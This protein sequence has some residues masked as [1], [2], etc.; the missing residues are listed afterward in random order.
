MDRGTTTLARRDLQNII[1]RIPRDI[2]ALMKENV[3]FLGGGFLRS[4]I[5]SEPPSDIDLFGPDTARLREQAKK[6]A[7]DRGGKMHETDNA[8]T[9]LATGRT[10]VQFIHRWLYKTPDRL[11]QE[12]DFTIARAVIWWKNGTWSSLCDNDYYADVA[13]RRLV[14]CKPEREE[15]VGGSLMR[16][17]KFL[18]N[19]YFIKAEDLGLVVAR[20]CST[21]DFT[22]I[23]N[24]DHLEKAV[25]GKLREV[26]PLIVVDGVELEDEHASAL[27]E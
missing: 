23:E 27:D 14:Y 13:A 25:I 15:D 4:T 17:R 9:V 6:L 7:D 1:P 18:R 12:F 21:I 2:R 5:Q 8:F 26:D 20:L 19:G 10:P 11:I 24:A 22:K 16:V 3:L